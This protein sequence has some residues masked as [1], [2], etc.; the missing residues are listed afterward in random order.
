MRSIIKKGLPIV[1]LAAALIAWTPIAYAVHILDPLGV[2]IPHPPGVAIP[3]PL[4]GKTFQDLV[5][6][7]VDFAELLLA[8]LSAI[9][10][11]LAG[12]FYMTAGGNPE[13]IKR[14]HKTLLWALAG[15]AVV[16]LAEVACSIVATALGAACP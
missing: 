11:L 8:P 13:K 7:F 2:P 14:A 4:G 10:V 5:G 16:L 12:F 1:G 15:I 3:D 6:K 9:M